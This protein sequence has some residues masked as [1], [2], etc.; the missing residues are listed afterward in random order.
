MSTTDFNVLG[1][2][3]RGY[4]TASDGITFKSDAAYRRYLAR[5]SGRQRRE[6]IDEAIETL[7]GYGYTVKPPKK[8][9]A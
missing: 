5:E 2:Q 7:E 6:E 4:S 1:V 3:M 9:R 8:K